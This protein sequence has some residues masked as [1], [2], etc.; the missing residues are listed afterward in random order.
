MN[1]RDS[2][3]PAFFHDAPTLKV[4]DPLAEFLGAATGGVIEYHY[5]DAV[6]L[7]GHSCPTVAGAWLMTLQGLRVLYGGEL[8]VRGEIS[9]FVGDARDSGA[10]GV[11]ATIVQLLTGAADDSGFRGIAGRFSRY[12]LLSFGQPVTGA[13]GLRR[14]DTGRAVQVALDASVVPWPQE[15]HSLMPI[16]VSG[17]ASDD[18]LARFGEIWQDRVRRMLVE[19]AD[20]ARMIQVSEWQGVDAPA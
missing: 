20:D 7:A 16:A 17:H 6:R 5:A 14:N 18:D 10:T 12:R 13:F 15:M 19:Y 11:M 3:F 4:R 2:A 8:P 1:T 9:V